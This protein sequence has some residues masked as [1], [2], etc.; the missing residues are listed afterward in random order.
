MPAPSPATQPVAQ[1]L[2][3]DA[4]MPGNV[5]L[6]EAGRS[7]NCVNLLSDLIHNREEYTL[8]AYTLQVFFIYVARLIM[9]LRFFTALLLSHYR[10]AARAMIAGGYSCIVGSISRLCACKY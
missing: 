6:R 10:V 7:A 8:K 4:E 2:R 1:R 9:S 3:R 5:G